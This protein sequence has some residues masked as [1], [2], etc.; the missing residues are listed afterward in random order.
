MRSLFSLPHFCRH[1]A[2]S[3]LSPL[4]TRQPLRLE[5]SWYIVQHDH[6]TTFLHKLFLRHPCLYNVYFLIT[7]KGSSAMDPLDYALLVLG[8]W[9]FCSALPATLPYLCFR[10]FDRHPLHDSDKISTP[11]SLLSI[12]P[13]RQFLLLFAV[14]VLLILV[15]RVQN[16]FCTCGFCICFVLSYRFRVLILWVSAFHGGRNGTGR[17]C[18]EG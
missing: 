4:A 15:T 11:Y 2:H 1:S 13:T 9:G 5:T 7:G 16:F 12:F 3:P 6:C 10:I 14:G 8:H 18:H 17:G